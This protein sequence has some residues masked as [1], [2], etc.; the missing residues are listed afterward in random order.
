MTALAR[1]HPEQHRARRV[2][3]HDPGGRCLA[4][5][6]VVDEAR[7]RGAVA[8][9]GEAMRQAPILQRLRGRTPP[10]LDV[11][12]HFDRGGKARSGGHACRYMI[13]DHAIRILHREN[14][15]HQQQHQHAD[16]EDAE[17]GRHVVRCGVDIGVGE[18]RQHEDPGHHDEDQVRLPGHPGEDDQDVEQQ[19]KLELA[20]VAVADL[21]RLRGPGRLAQRDVADLGLAATDARRC[22][23]APSRSAARR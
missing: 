12:E 7:D 5:Q 4:A 22:A 10:R 17:T 11:G 18:T 23:R 6:R 8:R 15:P 13:A 3:A 9:A 1:Q 14:D 16:R 20:V 21:R 19:R 2:G